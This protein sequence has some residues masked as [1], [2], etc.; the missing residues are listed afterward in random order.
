MRKNITI[1]ALLVVL[2]IAD[3]AVV[4]VASADNIQGNVTVQA[5]TIGI[6]AETAQ[7]NFGDLFP[8][9]T[10]SIVSRN[11][12]VSGVGGV[13]PQTINVYFNGTEWTGI[14]PSN[15]MPS[16][17]TNVTVDGGFVMPIPIPLSAYTGMGIAIHTMNFTV[18]IP[19]AQPADTYSQTITVTGIS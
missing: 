14:T 19:V 2:A 18:A 13:C 16:T 3:V 5:C 6:S 11:L 10:S 1:A 15:T 8:S 4:D 7:M 17:Q 9:Q 12:T